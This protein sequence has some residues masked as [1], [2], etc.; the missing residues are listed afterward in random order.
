MVAGS[1]FL[2]MVPICYHTILRYVTTM[3]NEP[4][5]SP[6]AHVLMSVLRKATWVAAALLLTF[7]GL[8]VLQRRMPDGSI[9]FQKGDMTF[10]AVLA[11]L[12]LLA[13]Y[14][15]RGIRK[16]MERPGE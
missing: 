1:F 12:M 6:L 3:D 16:E 7:A 10:L 4:K 8:L 5:M 13:I 9:V 14:L 15:I 2:L 11:A